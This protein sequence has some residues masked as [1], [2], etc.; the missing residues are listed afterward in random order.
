MSCKLLCITGIVFFT[1]NVYVAFNAD[2]TEHKQAFYTTL[3]PDLK[4]KYETIVMN[5]R[6]I[7]LKGYAYGLLLSA[8]IILGNKYLVK[9]PNLGRGGNVGVM[10]GVTLLTNYFYYML[11]P[12]GDLMVTHLDKEEQRLAWQKIYRTMQV[13]YHSGLLL[14]VVASG[15]FGAS[16]CALT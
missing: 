11:S 14:G 3:T 7:Y 4:A 16:I 9:K 12:K 10:V 1:A 6:D 8:A 13:S 5:R 2:K 15:F